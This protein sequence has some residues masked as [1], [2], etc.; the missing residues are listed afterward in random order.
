MHILNFSSETLS[1]TLYSR[2]Q[3][4]IQAFV[5]LVHICCVQI[6]AERYPGG[7]VHV[8]R[9]GLD[10]RYSR[11]LNMSWNLKHDRNR[12]VLVIMLLSI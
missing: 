4:S 2:G 1:L 3:Q 7:E 5:Y 9:N 6:S 10:S 11:D 8:G 12:N